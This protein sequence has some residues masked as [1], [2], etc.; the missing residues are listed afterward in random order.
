MPQMM[1]PS[2]PPATAALPHASQPR[3]APVPIRLW[4]E[5]F[6]KEKGWKTLFCQTVMQEQLPE[7][8]QQ[9]NQPRERWEH[10]SQCMGLWRASPDCHPNSWDFKRSWPGIT[11]TL[12]CTSFEYSVSLV[13]FC[14]VF[15][16]KHGNVMLRKKKIDNLA[17]FSWSLYLATVIDLL[18]NLFWR[19]D[20]LVTKASS[21]SRADKLLFLIVF[22]DTSEWQDTHPSKEEM[23]CSN[24]QKIEEKMLPPRW[25]FKLKLLQRQIFL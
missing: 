16:K 10:G 19:G 12:S 6:Q 2:Q 14:Y 25:N 18:K 8:C 24:T 15:K 17:T 4:P 22:N 7:C 23:T 11:S 1:L 3:L 13:W 21:H 5:I 9:D 20:I